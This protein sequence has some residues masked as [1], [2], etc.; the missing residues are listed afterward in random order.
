MLRN[1]HLRAFHDIRILSSNM[2]VQ[3][4]SRDSKLE[5]IDVARQII[6][7]A[8]KER[9]RIAGYVRDAETSLR[10]RASS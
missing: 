7:G 10:F 4:R 2:V 9:Q 3:W 6:R 8:E 1:A 5:E